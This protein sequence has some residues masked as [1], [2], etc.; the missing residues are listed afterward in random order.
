LQHSHTLQVF[1]VFQQ[2]H[3]SWASSTA[4]LLIWYENFTVCVVENGGYMLIYTWFDITKSSISR[5]ENL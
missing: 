1:S 3:C 4:N 5:T 2:A